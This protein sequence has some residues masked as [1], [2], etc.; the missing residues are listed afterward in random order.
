MANNMILTYLHKLD[1][2]DLPLILSVTWRLRRP[3]WPPKFKRPRKIWRPR[4]RW[5]LTGHGHGEKP[6]PWRPKQCGG[7]RRIMYCNSNTYG[8]WFMVDIYNIYNYKYIYIYFLWFINQHTYN[9]GGA[10][11]WITGYMNFMTFHS[12]GNH[13]PNWR[14]PLFFRGVGIP[15]TR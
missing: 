12:A 14:T 5:I 9:W 11:P 1:P 3:S 10:P 7:S 6:W 15:P 8:L 4:I 13:H 2:E